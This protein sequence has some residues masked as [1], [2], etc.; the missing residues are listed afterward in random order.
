MSVCRVSNA[1]GT[2]TM[3]IDTETGDVRA[4]L[5]SASTAAGKDPKRPIE[6][7]G[8][9]LKVREEG[10][11]IL[12]EVEFTAF[13]ARGPDGHSVKFTHYPSTAGAIRAGNV[14]I[15]TDPSVVLEVTRHQVREATQIVC[16][17]VDL[18][19]KRP[20]TVVTEAAA[21]AA[22]RASKPNPDAPVI[23]SGVKLASR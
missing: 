4:N 2:M 15:D 5:P 21:P 23:P 6:A 7:R 17:G 10:E 1:S 13:G 16:D 19:G 9:L 14:N 11:D 3:S 18:A 22:K 8:T 12:L 20:V